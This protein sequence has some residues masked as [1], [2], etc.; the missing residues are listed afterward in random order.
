MPSLPP[1]M[2]ILSI[3]AKT[4]QKLKLNFSRSAL[5]HTNTK[6]CLIYSGQDC[7]SVAVVNSDKTCILKSQEVFSGNL[8]IRLAN[9]NS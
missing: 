5:F 2:K 1:K 8:G 6:V 3:L 7:S 9:P 4:V